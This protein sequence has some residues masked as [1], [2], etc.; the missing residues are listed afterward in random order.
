MDLIISQMCSQVVTLSDILKAA[1]R[2]FLSALSAPPTSS[3]APGSSSFAA[4][5][6]ECE[7][8][9]I[10]KP[11]LSQQLQFVSIFRITFRS[12]ARNLLLLWRLNPYS[13]GCQ[14]RPPCTRRSAGQLPLVRFAWFTFSVF[15]PCVFCALIQMLVV[16]ETTRPLSSSVRRPFAA[17]LARMAARCLVPSVSDLNGVLFLGCVCISSRFLSAAAARRL[18]GDCPQVAAGPSREWSKGRLHCAEERS[19]EWGFLCCLSQ[20]VVPWLQTREG[21]AGGPKRRKAKL[22]HKESGRTEVIWC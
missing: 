19:E 11:T 18:R 9:H 12:F 3:A 20:R 17:I 15:Q 2:V 6:E 8:S 14:R 7:S 1:A 13:A 16:V 4:P 5:G 22:E 10:G 21:D